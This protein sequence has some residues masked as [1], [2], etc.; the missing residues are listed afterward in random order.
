LLDVH[1]RPQGCAALARHCRPRVEASYRAQL[2]EWAIPAP[3][4]RGTEVTVPLEYSPP[5]G[6][7]GAMVASLFGGAPDQH[8]REDLRRFKALME[9]GETP[10]T[11]GQS[12]G[13][14]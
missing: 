5:L 7:A 11:E 14:R 13:R 3:G 6:P 4:G 2:L 10:T 9:A 8:V 1:G 12:S